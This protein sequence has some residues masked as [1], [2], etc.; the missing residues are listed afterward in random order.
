MTMDLRDPA[1]RLQKMIDGRAEGEVVHEASGL[2]TSD[3][4]AI[5]IALSHQTV[6]D[7]DDDDGEL[8]AEWRDEDE[9]EQRSPR[10]RFDLG[11]EGG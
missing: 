6:L 8:V 11:G 9:E 4:M 5:L 10:D 3:V 1:R 2:T 7:D